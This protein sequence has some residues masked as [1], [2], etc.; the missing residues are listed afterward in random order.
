MSDAQVKE[1]MLWRAGFQLGLERPII[2]QYYGCTKTYYQQI[3][4]HPENNCVI[5]LH[6]DPKE[7]GV[8]QSNLTCAW[9]LN[10]RIS[11]RQF[12]TNFPHRDYGYTPTIKDVFLVQ[13]TTS[14]RLYRFSAWDRYEYLKQHVNFRTWKKTPYLWLLTPNEETD[15]TIVGNNNT[16]ITRSRLLQAVDSLKL[17]RRD[18]GLE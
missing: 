4:I 7:N 8:E 12:E 5:S 13:Y 18:F 17:N 15:Q 11:T 9:K 3:Y 10:T 16:N 14:P 2:R 1:I 6:V